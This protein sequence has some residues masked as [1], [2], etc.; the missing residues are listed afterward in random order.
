MA[1]EKEQLLLEIAALKRQVDEM[2]KKVHFLEAV[3]EHYT[4]EISYYANVEAKIRDLFTTVTERHNVLNSLDYA[5]SLYQRDASEE[6]H[7]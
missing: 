2:S 1:E 5:L 4:R 3:Q 6:Q 7:N